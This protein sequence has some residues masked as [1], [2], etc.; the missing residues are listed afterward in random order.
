MRK[1]LFLLM[2]LVGVCITVV[3]GVQLVMAARFQEYG[4]VIVYLI[5]LLLA[6]ELAG[7]GL[8]GFFSRKKDK[9]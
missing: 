5:L 6:G 3:C 1:C 7:Y 2:A 8:F 4:R 9:E